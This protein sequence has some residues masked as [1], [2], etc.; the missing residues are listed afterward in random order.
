MPTESCQLLKKF[1]DELKNDRY[2][3]YAILITGVAACL[4]FFHLD[5]NSLWLD[6]AVT[7]DIAKTS[8]PEI[9]KT[10]A[11]GEYNPPL[12]NWIEHIVT[13]ISTSEWALRFVPA[14]LGTLTVLIFFY[15]YNVKLEQ[16]P[17]NL[18]QKINI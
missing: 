14:L 17:Y 7:H 2:T 12:F 16:S 9:W 5:F 8:F 18:Y 10:T 1:H 6:E 13:V 11:G 4:R 15:L 3:Q